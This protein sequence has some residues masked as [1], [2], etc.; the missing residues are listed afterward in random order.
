MN[1]E[2]YAFLEKLRATRYKECQFWTPAP[3]EVSAIS[4]WAESP[5][6]HSSFLNAAARIADAHLRF[7]S[8]KR[9]GCMY[10][11]GESGAGKSSVIAWYLARNPIELRTDFDQI[12]VLVV[13][14][15]SK[16]TVKNF[17]EAVLRA[18][19]A[20]G[21]H[22]GT[23]NEKT[24]RILDLLVSHGVELIFIDEFQ[25]FV[26]HRSAATL[27]VTD[28]LKALVDASKRAVVLVGLP[29]SEKIVRQNEQLRRRFAKRCELLPFDD[30][31]ERSWLEFRSVLREL[32]RRS[33]VAAEEFFEPDLARR[34]LNASEGLM[35][36]LVAIVS[37]AIDI[38]S[39][40][41]RTLDREILAAAFEEEVW[42]GVPDDLNPFVADGELRPLRGRGEPFELCGSKQ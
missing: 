7:V 19:G 36:Y 15:P 16:P 23:E 29:R 11:I 18:L 35:S 42:P 38:A 33:P 17:A 10:L 1:T 9:G 2:R 31:T 41:N 5:I 20:P 28:W 13:Q 6:E 30:N 4:S 26:D 3:G 24:N 32:H 27:E 22:K 39:R 37:G 12:P 34:F 25:H 40:T 8:R 14:T 21:V